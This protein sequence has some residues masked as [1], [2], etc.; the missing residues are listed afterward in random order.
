MAK[1]KYQEWLKDDNLKL[2]ESWARD[3]LND[4]QIAKNMGINVATL[5][6]YKNKYS[7]I[8]KAI[9]KGKAPVDLEVENALY[10]SAMGE[11]VTERQTI[12]E[13]LKDGTIKKKII[14]NKKYIPPNPTSI[15]FWLKNRKPALW[16]RVSDSDKMKS[17]IE[18][19]K[20]EIEAMKLKEELEAMKENKNTEIIIVDEWK[21]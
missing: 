10:K 15:I 21:E 17:E 3:G 2:L 6:K 19:K 4:E 16:Q 1:G 11:W 5:Y 13:E 9:K 18:A 14:N 20:L 7:E 8:D 12:I